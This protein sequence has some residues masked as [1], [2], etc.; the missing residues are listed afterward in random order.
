VGLG[1]LSHLAADTIAHNWYVPRQLLLTSSTKGLGH[2]YWEAR[3]DTHMGDRYMR[4]ARS[5]VMDHDHT[6][7]DILFDQVLSSTLFS[8]RTNRRIFRG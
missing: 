7:A 8:F 3:M 5:V 2:S 6:A 4:L 1:Y